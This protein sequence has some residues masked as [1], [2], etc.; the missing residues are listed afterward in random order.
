MSHASALYRTNPTMKEIKDIS[1]KMSHS[2]DES[3]LY[4]KIFIELRFIFF[5]LIYNIK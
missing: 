4:N 2:P 5:S 1:L 3:R